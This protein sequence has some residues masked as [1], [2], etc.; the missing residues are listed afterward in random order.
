MGA[1][2]YHSDLQ[3][4]LVL[5]PIAHAV[6]PPY[7]RFP[8]I[9]RRFCT[10]SPGAAVSA[11]QRVCVKGHTDLCHTKLGAHTAHAGCCSVL[12]SQSVLSRTQARS[13]TLGGLSIRI[14]RVLSEKSYS[15][16]R[17]DTPRYGQMQGDGR[18]TTAS[19]LTPDTSSSTIR[20]CSGRQAAGV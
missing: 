9:K 4:L 5:S 11:L 20:Q 19:K 2:T 6:H 14:G 16:D 15:S 12:Y 8:C 3:S 10:I 18:R 13:R 1:Y 7:S 17:S